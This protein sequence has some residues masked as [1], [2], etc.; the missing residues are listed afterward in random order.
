MFLDDYGVAAVA[1][2]RAGK[3]SWTKYS[4]LEPDWLGDECA[5]ARQGC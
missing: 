4:G 5:E 1:G 3:R 2:L